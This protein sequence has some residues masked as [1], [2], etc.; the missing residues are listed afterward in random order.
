MYMF[1]LNFYIII[2]EVNFM[3]KLFLKTALNDY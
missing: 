1:L 2:E 3:P